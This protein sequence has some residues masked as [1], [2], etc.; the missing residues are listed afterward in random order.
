MLLKEIKDW[1]FEVYLLTRKPSQFFLFAD[2]II[3]NVLYQ[4]L[5]MVLEFALSNRKG[6]NSFLQP[7]RLPKL[8][9]KSLTYPNSE[10]MN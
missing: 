8:S 2:W 5:C 4:I 1:N 10:N 9:K 7:K 6:F 3:E